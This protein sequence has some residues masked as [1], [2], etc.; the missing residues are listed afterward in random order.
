M[1][2]L[3]QIIAG[4]LAW[5]FLILFKDDRVAQMIIERYYTLRFGEV[6]EFTKE[7]T[8]RGEGGFGSAGVWCLFLVFE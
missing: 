3:I 8:E 1:E 4:L 5:S 2:R 6:S 7:K